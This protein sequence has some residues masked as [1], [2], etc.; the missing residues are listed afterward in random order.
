MDEARCRRYPY[1]RQVRPPRP[2]NAASSIVS[3]SIPERRSR[4]P[5]VA[6]DAEESRSFCFYC[7]ARGTAESEGRSFSDGAEKDAFS[8]RSGLSPRYFSFFL[9]NRGAAFV[10]LLRPLVAHYDVT[11]S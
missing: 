7:V 10:A 11:R 5:E 9:P 2:L 8:G 1:V 6:K 4:F 3:T